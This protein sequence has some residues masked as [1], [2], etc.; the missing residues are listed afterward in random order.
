M[1]SNDVQSELQNIVSRIKNY[2]SNNVSNLN[3]VKITDRP[4]DMF[5]LSMNLYGKYD[6]VA[7]YDRSTLGFSVKKNGE[8][9]VLSKFTK[10]RIYRWSDSYSTE[11]KIMY[12]FQALEDVLRS[13]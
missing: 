11:S 9:V 7:E 3:I 8:Y 10:Y 5:T 6:V 13:M 12:N 4:F 1:P 2:W